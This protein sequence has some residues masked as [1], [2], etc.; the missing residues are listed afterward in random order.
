VSDHVRGDKI[1]RDQ[2]RQSGRDNKMTVNNTREPSTTEIQAAAAEL[3][4]FI[5]QLSAKGMVAPD[6]SVTDPAGVV[7][8]VQSQPGRL[9]ALAAAIAGGAK[10]AVLDLVKDGVA[11]LIAGLVGQPQ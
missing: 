4:T 1:G 8:A 10:D 3:R 6:G 5:A 11:T 7:E 9:R 2:Y